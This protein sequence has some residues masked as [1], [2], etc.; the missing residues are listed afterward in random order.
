MKVTC[1]KCQKLF[2]Y[3]IYEQELKQE[4]ETFYRTFFQ[5]PFCGSEFTVFYDSVETYSLKK[6]INKLKH[7][8][9]KVNTEIEYQKVMKKIK[10]KLSRLNREE[11]RIKKLLG[12]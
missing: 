10:K 1:D 12:V 11:E 9:D 4:D 5:C 7:E 2:D 8:L 3:Y 6:K